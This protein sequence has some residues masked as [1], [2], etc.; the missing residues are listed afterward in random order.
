MEKREKE[1]KERNKKPLIYYMDEKQKKIKKDYNVFFESYPQN[2]VCINCSKKL[3]V[4]VIII[5]IVI[6]IR[7]FWENTLRKQRKIQ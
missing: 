4:M 6:I 3:K 5:L 1:A 7:V 2:Y